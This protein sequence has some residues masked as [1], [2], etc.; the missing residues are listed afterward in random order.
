[1]KCEGGQHEIYDDVP[2]PMAWGMMLLNCFQDGLQD[3]LEMFYQ[4]DQHGVLL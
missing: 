1:M 4:I 2:R 3:A